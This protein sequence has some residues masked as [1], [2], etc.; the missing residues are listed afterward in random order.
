MLRKVF[1]WIVN[2]WTISILGLLLLA[3]L[4]W[5]FGPAFAFAGHVPLASEAARWIT[6]AVIVLGWLTYQA[7]VVVR[8]RRNNAKMLD[9]LTKA[10]AVEDPQAVAAREEQES[11][12]ERF[13]EA[14]ATLKTT[15][16]GGGRSH[17]QL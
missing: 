13:R 15:K 3:V 4:I 5:V 10:P 14:L 17:R 11:L 2:R 7:V 16:L 1:G 12:A 9:Q 8:Q 6:I